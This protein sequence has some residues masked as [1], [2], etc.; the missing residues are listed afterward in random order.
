MKKAFCIS[1]LV[2]MLLLGLTATN[3]NAEKMSIQQK[4]NIE[5]KS[6]KSKDFIGPY[7]K[8][9]NGSIEK[10]IERINLTAFPETAGT[11]FPLIIIQG[12]D[13]DTKIFIGPPV[14][15]DE[16]I[17][18]WPEEGNNSSDSSGNSSKG[19]SSNVTVEV[20]SVSSEK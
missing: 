10:I 8:I 1:L 5:S 7:K 11:K 13:I 16:N 9:E 17:L 2:F 20:K 15:I 6:D 12:P 19:I 14:K 18:K 4:G 3:S